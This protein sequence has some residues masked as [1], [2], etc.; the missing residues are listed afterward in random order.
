MLRNLTI[1]SRL[2]FILFFMGA[3]LLGIEL[4]GLFGMSN[5]IDGL[6]TVY[7]DRAIPL[8]QVA[9]IESLL[10][11]NRLAITSALMMPTP[12]TIQSK[13]AAIDQDIEELTRIWEDYI[14]TYLTPEEK[15]LALQFAEDR[16]RFLTEGIKAAVTALRANEVGEAYRIL[17]EKIRPL[18]DPVNRSIKSLSKLQLDEIGRE[19]NREQNRFEAIRNLLIASVIIALMLAAL[20][21]IMVSRT[22]FRPLEHVVKISRGV[23]AGNFMQEIEVRSKNEI[24]QLMQALKEMRDS[25]VDTIRQIRE[26]EAHTSALLSN[27][28]DGVASIDEKG[29][30]KTFNPAAERIFDYAESELIGQNV[31]LLF[32]QPEPE[33]GQYADY[34]R[35]Y[36]EAKKSAALGMTNEVTGLRK[37][38]TAFPMDLAVVEIHGSEHRMFVAMMRDISERKLVEEQK[39]RLMAELESANEEL[40]DFAY[41]VSHDLKSPLRAIGALADWLSTDYADK[42]DDEGKEHMRL[43]VSRVHRMSNLIDGILQYSRVGRVKEALIKLDL[44]QVVQEVI[45]LLS[46]PVNVTISVEAPLPNIIAE[47]TRVQQIFQ[48]LL[49]NAIKYMDK[50]RGEI[51]IGCSAEGDQWKFSVSDNGPGIEPRHFEKIFQLFQTLAPR[52]RIES[53]GVGLALVKKIVEMYG[54]RIWVESV[55]GE[56]S[57]F[58]FTLPQIAEVINLTKGKEA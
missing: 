3:F 27:L 47:P 45:D 10:L 56:G 8:K 51:R 22:I 25:L 26:S 33:Q 29:V 52:D 2:I 6:K 16:D 13:T 42:F 48:N 39:S 50:P 46:P 23:A 55:P 37:N 30:I 20:I 54:G 12:E 18:Y 21:S 35:Q 7:H 32:P 40:K 28:I 49:S 15:V 58:F 38:G 36:L 11:R 24:G 57:T 31:N 4:L 44:G 14:T 5:A 43:L 53:T 19:Y 1:K 9:D 34:F 41:V 17:V